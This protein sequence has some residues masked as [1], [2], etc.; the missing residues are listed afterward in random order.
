MQ[1]VVGI[2]LNGT[3][4]QLE[5]P[6]Y[7]ALRAYLERAESRLQTN[8]D[9]LEIMADLE[10]AVAEKC[11]RY[12]GPNK[13]VVTAVEIETII[14][15][16]GPVE[17]PESTAEAETSAGTGAEKPA[18]EKGAPRRLYQIRE[19]AMLSGVCNG[20]AAFFDIDVTVVRVVFVILTFATFGA[21]ILGYLIMAIVIPYADTPEDRAAAYGLRLKARELLDQANL[22]LASAR[23]G[24]REWRRTWRRQQRAWQRSWNEQRHR[25]WGRHWEQHMAEQTHAAMAGS[26]PPMGHFGQAVAGISLPVLAIVNA[27]MFVAWILVMI[28]AAM[29]GTI[30]GWS[31]PA[32]LPLWGSLLILFAIYFVLTAPLRAARRG[33]YHAWGPYYGPWAALSGLFWLGFTVLF[34]WLAYQHIPEVHALLDQLPALWQK[35]Q[36]SFVV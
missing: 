16:M 1:K 25:H 24:R 29:T 20:I 8:P 10:Q 2:N 19:G 15:E 30:F 12:L 32:D 28:S 3:A 18:A 11:G 31:L 6:G 17:S 21:W 23:R 9:R 22:H 36:I 13:T 33:A 26:V 34:F 7:E 14:R 35:R 4:Y 5:E 27:A